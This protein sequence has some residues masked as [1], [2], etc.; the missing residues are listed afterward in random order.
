MYGGAERIRWTVTYTGKMGE[1]R[2]QG[3]FLQR[4]NWNS[5]KKEVKTKNKR[6]T[7]PWEN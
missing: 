5:R 7:V 4:V 2:V 1:E 3:G 6:D